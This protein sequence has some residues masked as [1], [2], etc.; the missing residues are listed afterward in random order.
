MHLLDNLVMDVLNPLIKS[1]YVLQALD[2]E[3]CQVQ[4]NLKESV[5]FYAMR[6]IDSVFQQLAGAQKEK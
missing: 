5:V 2:Q 4:P 6:E 1:P 3:A